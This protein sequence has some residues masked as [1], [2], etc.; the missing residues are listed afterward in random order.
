MSLARGITYVSTSSV[1]ALLGAL[2]FVKV[3]ADGS[4]CRLINAVFLFAL[5][6]SVE[7]PTHGKTLYICTYSQII[8]RR[9]NL[10]LMRKRLHS[11][12]STDSLPLSQPG[13]RMPAAIILLDE[14]G[15]YKL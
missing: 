13:G 15:G 9:K 12:N 10:T 8:G 3:S 11:M 2:C 5:V 1:C 14:D 7:S 4:P 6:G